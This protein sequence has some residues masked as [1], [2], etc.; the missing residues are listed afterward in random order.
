MTDQEQTGR[1]ALPTEIGT[2]VQRFGGAP[3]HGSGHGRGAGD[4]G[5]S[6]ATIRV[7]AGILRDRWRVILGVFVIVTAGV[8]ASTL[9][10]PQV[11]RA[12]ATLEIRR[13][14]AEVV[15]VESFSQFERISDQYLQTQYAV[16]RGPAI[17]RRV[18]SDPALGWRLAERAGFLTEHDATEAVSAPPLPEPLAAQL[19]GYLQKRL[20][21]DPVSNSRI[22]RISLELEDPALAADAVNALI[23]EY[24]SARE[25]AVSTTLA[26]LAEQAESARSHVLLAEEE[27]QRFVRSN[28]LGGVIGEGGG[29]S[30]A[31]ERLRRLQQELTAAETEAYEVEALASATHLE[32]AAMTESDLLKTLRGRVAELEGEYARLRAVFTDS[33]PRTRQVR[34]ELDQLDSMLA[35]EERRVT[36]KLAGQHQA[37]MRRRALLGA[38][39]DE[40]RLL[41][42]SLAAKLAEHDRLRRDL[43]GQQQLYATL[44]QKRKEAAISAAL[45][46][47]DVAVLDAATPPRSAIRPVP[48]RDIPLGALVGLMLGLALAFVRH[49]TDGSVRTLDDVEGLSQTH[50]L[51]MIPAT[52]LPRR[53]RDMR[54]RGSRRINE[55]H[56]IDHAASQDCPLD[57]AFSGLR[58]AVLFDAAARGKRILMVSS[59]QPA[60]GKTTVSSNLAISLARLGQ[61]VLLIDADLRRPSVH[62]VFRRPQ[63]P[64]LSQY[65]GGQAGWHEVVQGAFTTGLD[66]ITAGTGSINAADC[67]SSE[68]MAALLTDA[69]Q[70]YDYVLLDAP[71]LFINVPD[72]RIL[73]HMVEGVILVVGSGV[74]VRDVVQRS[75]EH[76]GNL[77]GVVLNRL[78][79][80][81]MPT[82]Y[83]EYG[84]TKAS[85]GTRSFMAWRPGVPVNR[86][87]ATDVPQPLGIEERS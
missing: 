10:T 41:M 84:E 29:E 11:Y 22:V 52:A 77:M 45:S 30:M 31:V 51:G 16:L 60:E 59:S 64:G 73:A 32:S 15:P 65:L 85:S 21:V 54:I 81:H 69:R 66:I 33:F 42:D 76:V 46:A 68:R 2:T 83:R 18:A 75:I 62:E 37:T 13:Q 74:A 20:I 44:Q 25:E 7:Y 26:R 53:S 38:A 63:T 67:L 50:V 61:R 58:T 57:D 14:A 79:L 71:A 49:L 80:R 43:S 1:P 48:D 6:A 70:S 40:Q 23:A 12:T 47:M 87:T 4:G 9:T 35:R 8:A 24:Q 28:G 36:T 78:D 39:V 17:V 55:W 5:E 86:D 82:Y 27:L 34:T 3:A 19:V 72:A 56:R